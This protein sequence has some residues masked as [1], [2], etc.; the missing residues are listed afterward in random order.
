MPEGRRRRLFL[1]AEV[2]L[3]GGARAGPHPSGDAAKPLRAVAVDE[4]DDEDHHVWKVGSMLTGRSL[5][6][7]G[8]QHEPSVHGFMLTDRGSRAAPPDNL[9]PDEFAAWQKER[10]DFFLPW[11][12]IHDGGPGWQGK[13]DVA[14][15]VLRQFWFHPDSPIRELEIEVRGANYD[16]QVA[17]WQIGGGAAINP[18]G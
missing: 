1:K 12:S 3:V 18:K 8:R 14:F 4:S 16:G 7:G 5:E 15:V 2:P 10:T 11:R 13:S 17:D 6:R 9:T